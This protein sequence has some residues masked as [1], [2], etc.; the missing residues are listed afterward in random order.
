MKINRFHIAIMSRIWDIDKYINSGFLKT[1]CFFLAAEK[2]P[3]FWSNEFF[4]GE[5]ETISFYI[6][7]L[8]GSVHNLQNRGN[9]LMY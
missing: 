6:S 4:E 3:V 8:F 7:A 5:I 2:G 9:V 1:T